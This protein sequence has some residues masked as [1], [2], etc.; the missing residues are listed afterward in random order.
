[1]PTPQKS[2]TSRLTSLGA[3]PLQRPR[4]GSKD[5]KE[6]GAARCAYISGALSE[7]RPPGGGL[8][9]TLYG[10]VAQAK[11]PFSRDFPPRRYAA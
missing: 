9:N 10:S 3:V 8:E 5:E 2:R 1:M 6:D 7:E 4:S 11:A